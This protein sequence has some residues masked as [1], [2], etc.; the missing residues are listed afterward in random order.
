MLFELDQLRQQAA[1][2]PIVEGFLGV[3]IDERADGGTG[4][5]IADVS[6]GS[7]ADDAGLKVGDIV[8]AGSEWGRVRALLDDKG[9]AV[10]KAGPSVPVEVLGFDSAPEAG[11]QFAVVESEA[12]ARE[13]LTAVARRRWAGASAR[14]W[15]GRTATSPNR[16][17]RAARSSCVSARAARSVLIRSAVACI[18]GEAIIVASPCRCV[19]I[20]RSPPIRPRQKSFSASAIAGTVGPAKT[21]E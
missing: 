1:G 16:P 5:V 19:F 13:P 8:V 15:T 6:T 3:G 7:P 21:R 18:S 14:G 4:A 12:R 2:R 10:D 11:D 9:K 20:A 17:A